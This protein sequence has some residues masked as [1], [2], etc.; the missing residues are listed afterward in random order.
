M[1]TRLELVQEYI[2]SEIRRVG[3]C[4]IDDEKIAESWRIA[5]A[6]LA[7]NEK[8]EQE[9]RKKKRAEI[10]ELLNANNTFVEKEGQHFDDVEWQPDW[11]LA[12]KGFN[13]FVKQYDGSTHF[14][15]VKPELHNDWFAT[16]V[17]GRW[18]EVEIDCPI[19][20][21]ESLRKR[22]EGK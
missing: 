3:V 20:W 6:M 17:D 21:R 16:G 22:P 4:S 2:V 8:G 9:A 11:G 14:L 18:H 19:E 13:W 10:R 15:M 7:E 5:D 12:P 1:K